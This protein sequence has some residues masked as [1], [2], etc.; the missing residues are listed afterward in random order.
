MASL[1][2]RLLQIGR[3]SSAAQATELPLQP[4]QLEEA[5]ATGTAAELVPMRDSLEK[6]AAE[7]LS[8]IVALA[9]PPAEYPGKSSVACASTRPQGRMSGALHLCRCSAVRRTL[10]IGAS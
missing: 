1:M 5:L 2:T 8:Q 3:V 4:A 9:A 6:R 7:L 10:H